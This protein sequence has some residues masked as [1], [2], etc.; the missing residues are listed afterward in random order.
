MGGSLETDY[1]SEGRRFESCRAHHFFAINTLFADLH[2]NSQEF[3]WGKFGGNLP[4]RGLE[5]CPL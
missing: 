3:F 2:L 4:V 1:E 5:F